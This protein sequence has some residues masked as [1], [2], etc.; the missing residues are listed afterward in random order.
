VKTGK[1]RA[2]LVGHTGSVRS[3]VFSPDGK[4]LASGGWNGPA[5][6]WDAQTGKVRAT[7]GAH[8]SSV[9]FSPDGKMLASVSGHTVA[10]WDAKTG[11]GQTNLEGHTD[12][13]NSV[14]F[15][16]DGQFLV[17]K[18]DKNEI[19]IWDLR[20]G[21]GADEFKEFTK[22]ISSV[23]FSPDGKALAVAGLA[24]VLRVMD[25]L[26][27][28]QVATLVG[29]TDTIESVAFGPDGK[30]LVSASKD[31]TVMLWDVQTGKERTTFAV[32]SDEDILAVAFCSD[33]KTL[34]CV[35]RPGKKGKRSDARVTHWD[36]GTGKKLGVFDLSGTGRGDNLSACFS[37]DGVNLATTPDRVVVHRVRSDRRARFEKDGFHGA[38]AVF[39][40]S[41]SGKTLACEVLVGQERKEWA[42]VLLD[43]AGKDGWPSLAPAA[44]LPKAPA[45]LR[46]VAFSPDGR[47]LASAGGVTDDSS[48]KGEIRLWD[49]RTG[50]QLASLQDDGVVLRVAFSPDGKVLATVN[51]AGTL[52]L[53]AV[54]VALASARKKAE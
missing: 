47:V 2:T 3:V 29:H 45:G 11:K 23:A 35:C 17:S 5:R 28:K 4:T 53:W 33:G 40:F 22:T 52:K 15:G 54:E 14:V 42:L 9:V 31:R 39:A 16:P 44:V 50:R 24:P 51:G 34:D 46:S 43:V 21:R 32:D 25:A 12:S 49:A 8:A 1:M 7:V 13:V 38:R 30:R 18:G 26:T 10:L 37:P 27:G 20:S 19:R 36:L 6:L 41:P 48:S